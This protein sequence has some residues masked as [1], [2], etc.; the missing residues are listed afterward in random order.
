MCIGV[1]MPETVASESKVIFDKV[2]FDKPNAV[3]KVITLIE[4]MKAQV[5]KEG[6]EDKKAYDAYACWCKTNDAEKTAAIENA[7]KRIEDLTSAIEG[8]AALKAQLTTEI[9]KLEQDIADANKAL[10]TAA[11]E[12]EKE[13]AEF[14]EQEADMKEALSALSEAIEVLSK[15]QLLQKSG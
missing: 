5:E 3:R 1:S 14:K 10:E 13:A 11:A 15:V 8:F 9:E 12:R 2:D 4:E 6:D 7:E